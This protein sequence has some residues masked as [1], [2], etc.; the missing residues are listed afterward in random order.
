MFFCLVYVIIITVRPLAEEF[1]INMQEPTY[2]QALAKSWKLVWHRKSLWVLGL[3][4]VVLGQLGFSDIFGKAWSISKQANVAGYLPWDSLKTAII[5][6]GSSGKIVIGI[7]LVCVAVFIIV[8]AAISQGALISY[9]SAWYKDEKFSNFSKSWKIGVKHFWDVLWI[10]LIRRLLL[11]GLLIIVAFVI[12]SFFV[13][14]T[15]FQNFANALVLIIVLFVS[16]VISTI[17]IYSLCYC[18]I[19]GKGVVS[20]IG[21]AWKLFSSH[22]L[23]SLEVGVIL[24][25]LNVVLAGA[26]MLGAYL[27]FL[28]STLIWFAAGVTN[29]VV[30]AILGLM[31]GFLLWLIFMVIVAAFFNAFT[32][33]A[34]VFLFSKMHHEGVASRLIHGLAHMFRK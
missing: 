8:V 16:L 19:D 1:N 34:W 27:A 25:L 14:E 31:L 24:V 6:I 26:I 21:K 20:G 23:V 9:A 17:A 30:L 2:R 22:L 18:V 15:L 29:I 12:K 32:T 28:P 10:N 5:S 3:L 13:S 11:G 7:A 4:S 33:S